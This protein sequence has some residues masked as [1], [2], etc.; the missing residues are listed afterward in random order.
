MTEKAK[1][2]SFLPYF[3]IFFTTYLLLQIFL[4]PAQDPVLGSGD[5]GI[6]THKDS[7]SI[8][9]EI[10]VEVQNNT[11][12][13]VTILK[14][15]C[16]E[17]FYDAEKYSSD[18]FERIIRTDDTTLENSEE[19]N[20]GQSALQI[21][22]AGEKTRLLVSDV[23]TNFGEVGRYRLSIEV[24][25]ELNDSIDTDQFIQKLIT[26][27]FTIKEPGFITKAWRTLLYNPILNGLI[28][29]LIYMP[30]H[31]L[32]LA[33]IVL[34]L[35]IRTILLVPSRKAFE[36]QR[37][38]QAMQPKI[39]ALKEKYKDDQAR[40]AQETMALWKTHNIHPASSCLPLL[41]QFPI[42]I[43]LF[44]VI[45]SGLDPDKAVLIYE[46]LPTFSLESINSMFFN[47]NLLDRSYIVF[48]IAIGALQFFQLQIMASLG[49]KKE[50][51]KPAKD[52]KKGKG[53]G[54][55]MEQANK[56]MRTLM[57]VMIAFFATQMPAAVSL[58]WGTSTFYGIVQQLV[59]KRKGPAAPSKEDDV[60]VRVIHARK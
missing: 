54:K 17:F 56:M 43:A 13:A 46:F 19:T 18:G 29:L 34:T 49:K 42:L 12:E 28:A 39:N 2:P 23:Y 27:E 31:S 20:C 47:F 55:E 24:Q 48:P 14:N 8:G 57:P 11:A 58:Y 33:I 53:L 51:K 59:L 3:L 38:M 9:K 25:T 37:N 5:L 1:R 4:N 6:Q 60:K 16:N 50:D 44:Y 52:S 30:G 36:S 26:P 40:L 22:E 45:Q 7:Y 21:L 15:D 35:I 10:Q 41:I 32:A